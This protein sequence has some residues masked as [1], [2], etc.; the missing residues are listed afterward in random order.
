MAT[1][2]PCSKPAKR[3][4]EPFGQLRNHAYCDKQVVNGV[5]SGVRGEQ[6]LRGPCSDGARNKV[7]RSINNAKKLLF[8]LL[9]RNQRL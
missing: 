5:E 8:Q 2:V 3:D 7:K 4:E 9:I 1:G 6:K